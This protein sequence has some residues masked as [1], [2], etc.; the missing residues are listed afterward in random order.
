[1][2]DGRKQGRLS[3]HARKRAGASGRRT[4]RGCSPIREE[5]IIPT[6][7]EA[8]FRLHRKLMPLA[9]WY[10][11]G[12][13]LVVMG[14]AFLTWCSDNVSGQNDLLMVF[15][16]GILM[17]TFLFC[18]PLAIMNYLSKD[19]FFTAAVSVLAF[20]MARAHFTVMDTLG[21]GNIQMQ[22]CLVFLGV[23][24]GVVVVAYSKVLNRGLQNIH[25]SKDII[26]INFENTKLLKNI[27]SILHCIKKSD[28]NIVCIILSYIIVIII[29]ITS[30]IMIIMSSL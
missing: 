12:G 20:F 5:H 23:C 2:R 10:F 7:L 14:T 11:M 18:I 26:N 30:I 19:Y 13:T 28:I 6:H 24:L 22:A 25:S 29:I 15:L 9:R 17:L 8:R 27:K 1:M 16:A 3:I 4:K 21:T